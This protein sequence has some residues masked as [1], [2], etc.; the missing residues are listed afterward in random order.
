VKQ[1]QGHLTNTK[2]NSMRATQQ[3]EQSIYQI[4]TAAEL[5]IVCGHLCLQKNFDTLCEFLKIKI[6]SIQKKNNR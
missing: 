5:S 2:Q 4:Q 6:I 1:L 3:N